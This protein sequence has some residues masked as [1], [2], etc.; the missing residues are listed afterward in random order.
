ML[1][2]QGAGGV[3][4]LSGLNIDTDKDWGG[5]NITNLGAGGYDVNAKLASI[6]PVGEI[7]STDDTLGDLTEYHYFSS[8]AGGVDLV[9]VTAAVKLMGGI[10]AGAFFTNV[11]GGDYYRLNITV[12]GATTQTIP[13]GGRGELQDN[14]G[15]VAC[16]VLLPKIDANSSLNVHFYNTGDYAVQGL[17]WTLCPYLNTRI[18]NQL[19]WLYPDGRIHKSARAGWLIDQSAHLKRGFEWLHLKGDE[20]SKLPSDFNSM[21]YRW[22]FNSE[23][24]VIRDDYDRYGYT[25][26][27]ETQITPDLPTLKERKR[28]TMPRQLSA[29]EKKHWK[30]DSEVR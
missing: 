16:N 7:F 19:F 24:F 22:D 13:F 11:S 21:K 20:L 9:D 14:A 5:Y 2:P 18:P 1:A 4:A 28:L 26:L 6:V 30:L 8:A 25:V 3:S 23:T 12:D 15:D 29:T 10:A 17:A 27:I